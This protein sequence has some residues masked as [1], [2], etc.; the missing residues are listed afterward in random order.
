[1]DELIS[2]LGFQGNSYATFSPSD[3]LYINESHPEVILGFSSSDKK[4][5]LFFLLLP[6]MFIFIVLETANDS[7][8]RQLNVKLVVRISKDVLFDFSN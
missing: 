1:M 7:C 8:I 2:C 4:H 5:V 3:F 6:A